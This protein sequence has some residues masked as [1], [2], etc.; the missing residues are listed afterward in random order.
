MT[1]P[2]DNMLIALSRLEDL[3]GAAEW[4]EFAVV[5]TGRMEVNLIRHLKRRGYVER[6]RVFPYRLTDEGRKALRDAG[7][8]PPA[9]VRND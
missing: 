7:V 9:G 1:P 2:T 3:G 5:D 6:L 4:Q 8:V